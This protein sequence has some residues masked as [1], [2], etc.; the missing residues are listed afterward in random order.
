MQLGS[1]WQVG[2][3][4]HPGVP[5]LLHETIARIEA[6]REGAASGASWTLTWLEG[7][8]RVELIDSAATVLADVGV[9]ADGRV[10][11]RAVDGAPSPSDTAGDD[12]DEDDDDWLL[13]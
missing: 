1:R 2:D 8:A 4:P 11:E 13:G 3:A 6:E 10:T 7:R 12:D 9:T 5:E